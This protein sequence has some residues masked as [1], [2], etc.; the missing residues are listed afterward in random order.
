MGKGG[1]PVPLTEIQ[2]RVLTLLAGNRSEESYLAGAAGVHMSE[3]SPRK[4]ADLDLFHDHEEAVASAFERDRR[5]LERNHY[6]FTLQL[7]QPGFIRGVVSDEDQNQIR[8][9]WAYDSVWRFMPPVRLEGVGFVLHPV[10]LAVN[11]VLAL[12]GREEPR[13]FVDVVYLHQCVLPLGALAWAACGKDP[14]LNPEMLLELLSRRGRIR[15]EDMDRLDLAVPLDP[16]E[17]ER[18]YREALKE[19]KAWITTR[20]PEEAGCLY[21]RSES[22]GFFAPRA[23]EPCLVHWGRKGGVLP[24]TESHASYLTATDERER[25]ESFFDHRL[26]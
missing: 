3:A 8:V 6:S 7:S 14:G 4:S 18:I 22:G 9:D 5:L 20:P 24:V 19:G 2:K 26:Q 13:D 25:L 15:K 17:Q 21:R 23:D 10:D 1:S 11:K 16:V 12:V